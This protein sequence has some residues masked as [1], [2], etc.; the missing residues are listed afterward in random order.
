MTE[1][2]EIVFVA[3][4]SWLGFHTILGVFKDYE[5]ANKKIQDNL[6]REDLK[7]AQFR[8]DMARVIK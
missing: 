5:K 3:S 2:R 6:I 4:V 1:N 8:I 7:G